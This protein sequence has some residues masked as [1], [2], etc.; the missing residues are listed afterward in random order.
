MRVRGVH[1]KNFKRFSDLTI[2]D[3]PEQAR[4]VVMAGPNGTGKSSVFDGFRVWQS[5]RWRLG[6]DWD[7]AYF[8]KQ[9]SVEVGRDE[10]IDVTLYGGLP[11]DPDVYLKAFY[12]RSAYRNEPDFTTSQLQRIGTIFEEP[13]LRR[14]IDND[15][16]VGRNYQRLVS[17]SVE[18][19]YSGNY[20]DNTVRELREKFIGTVQT[21]MSRVFGDLVLSG[22][23]DPLQQGSFFFEKGN[24]K[25]FHY[26]N[27]SGGEKAAFDIILDVIVKRVAYD[28]TVYCLDEPEAHMHTRLQA[29]FLKE[30][31]SL[32]PQNSQ[33]WIATHS[34]GMMRAARDIYTQKQN[35]VVFL[36]FSDENFDQPVT[37][38]P[39]TV[40]R[41]FWRK[42]LAVVLDDLANLVAP[43]EVALCEGKPL[44][45]AGDW[46]AERDAQCYRQIF[47]QEFPDT[48]FLSVGNAEDV[49]NDRLEIGRAIQTLTSGTK[50]T[51]LI[52]RDERTNEEIEQLEKSGV[53]VLARR[54]LEAYLM[55]DEILTRLCQKFGQAEKREELLRAKADAISASIKRG[56][57]ANDI[58]SAAGEVFTRAR[59]ILAL[60]D[61]ACGSNTDA[62]LRDTLAPLITQDTKVYVDLKNEIFG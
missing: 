20:D 4:L 9:G 38:K 41:K 5:N 6:I 28:D 54:H 42:T 57:P 45:R 33:L 12:I 23:G 25:N 43:R 40:N 31:L 32:I 35:E 36:D 3:L 29:L 27:L 51:R 16:S 24:S 11:Q 53:R 19:V 21:S 62:F 52:D 47:G 10:Y 15:V 44:S 48:D 13:I 58:K 8:I 56:N 34:I 18:G 60:A 2:S 17:Q 37:L 22:P 46:K 30:L 14:L 61:K 59:D 7:K 55:D 26:K 50:G 49:K 1:L 39:S